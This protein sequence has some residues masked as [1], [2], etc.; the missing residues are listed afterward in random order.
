MIKKAL[1]TATSL[2]LFCVAVSA[3]TTYLQLGHVDYHLL[4]RLETRSGKLSDGLFLSTKPTSRKAAV[5]FLMETRRD[6][7]YIGLSKIDR[8]NIM[9]M[10]SVSGEWAE[11]GQGAID[12]K[13]PIFKTFYKKQPD[14]FYVNNDDLFLSINPVISVIGT[15]EQN[16]P[17]SP[18]FA[19]GR[20]VE[21]RG[22]ILDK[23]GLYTYFTDN[24]E[25]V[26][27]HVGKWVD[28]FSAV[29]AAD[30]YK[31]TGTNTYDYLLA[32]GYID[33]AAIKDHI[34][35]TFG[36]G[37]HFIGDGMRSLFLSDYSAAA[38]FL[39]INTRVWKLNY[40]NLYLELKPQYVRGS[41]KRLP[42]K[43]ATIH[44]LSANAFDWLNVGIFEAV[45]F[46]RQDRYE[47]SYMNPIILYRQIER[48]LGS[49][50]NV[51][52]GINFKAL[53]LKHIQ[54]YGQFILDEFTFSELKAGNGYWANKFG[55]QLGGKYFDAFT[56]NNL[57]LQGEINLVRPYTYTHYDSTANYSH[58]NQPLAHPLGAGFLEFIGMIRYQPIKNLYTEFKGTYYQQTTDTNGS[59]F[60]G[61][62]FMDYDNR[63]EQYG[64][65]L[66]NGVRAQCAIARF[67]VSYELRENLFIDAGATYRKKVYENAV[68]PT[69]NTTYFTGGLRLNI[70]RR[71]YDYY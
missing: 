7:R 17:G 52:L 56:V 42:R 3:Q 35:I 15:S 45:V 47:F 9:H 16:N 62:I 61:N 20:G 18:L 1:L 38:T 13:H 69:E 64:V 43:Y 12:S 4:D 46:D 21:V 71:D 10:V 66:I 2:L 30:Y 27:A 58:Y 14:L 26:P 70:T 29:P 31:I 68:Y 19:S 33:F 55:L 36:Y 60:G 25:E 8:H 57:D 49:P 34:N 6:A 67:N 28:S 54:L 41:D 48:S 32:R 40:Q 22:R 53:V 59:N 5:E 63:A 39:R 44:H 24:Q 37:R 23:I 11:E 65:S 51:L 50:D